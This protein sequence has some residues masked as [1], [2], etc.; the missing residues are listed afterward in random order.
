V[1][2]RV[3]LDFVLVFSVKVPKANV[4]FI[5]RCLHLD[6]VDYPWSHGVIKCPYDSVGASSCHRRIQDEGC[7]CDVV[8]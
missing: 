5:R 3:D 7:G 2:V 4:K 6:E 1:G 8:V